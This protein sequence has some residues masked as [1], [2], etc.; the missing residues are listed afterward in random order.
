MVSGSENQV[1]SELSVVSDMHRTATV[2]STEQLDRNPDRNDSPSRLPPIHKL[3]VASYPLCSSKSSVDLHLTLGAE[4]SSERPVLTRSRSNSSEP[5]LDGKSSRS[6]SPRRKETMRRVAQE[7]QDVLQQPGRA[8]SEIS[9]E[10]EELNDTA[11]VIEEEL[12][13]PHGRRFEKRYHTADG[14]DV[15]KPKGTVLQGGILKRFSW[16]VSSAVGASSRKIS[17]RLGEHS[18]RHSQA[19]TAASSESFGSST[20]GISSS[21]SHAENEVRS[22]FFLY[23]TADGIDVLKPKGTV[24]QGGILKRFSWNVSSAVGASS[25]KI[26]ARLGEHSRR[27]SQASTAASSE[28][29]GSSTSGISSS[30][31][32]AENECMK[33]HISTIAV[34]DED[35][36]TTATLNICLDAPDELSNGASTPSVPQPLQLTPPLPNMPPPPAEH[37]QKH[38]DLLRFIMENH[39]ETS[40]V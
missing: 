9:A 30:S 16:N 5:E 39:L 12:V 33:A 19:S 31:S 32:H 36:A 6:P 28:S 20:S 26:S 21:S 14:I 27:H 3:S 1:S 22:G 23:H 34:N 13:Q 18:R 24:L 35:A 2:S 38:E 7:V 11:T 29:F 4:T 37:G 10:I 25:R 8:K 40:D 15:L 17:A